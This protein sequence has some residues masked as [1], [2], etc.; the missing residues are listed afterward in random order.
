M[1]DLNE[2]L[3]AGILGGEGITYADR[4]VEEHGDYKK[5]AFVSFKTLEL[6]IHKKCS[7]DLLPLIREDHTRLLGKRGEEYEVS[8]CGQT[9]TLGWGT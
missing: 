6:D 4:R 5:C 2:A 8:T 3:F 1:R 9:V 7:K